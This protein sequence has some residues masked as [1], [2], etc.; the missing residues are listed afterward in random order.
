MRN[1]ITKL[2]NKNQFFLKI[3]MMSKNLFSLTL[4]NFKIF[5][6]FKVCISLYV[7]YS[8]DKITNCFQKILPYEKICC[9]YKKNICLLFKL[10]LMALK[11]KL[12]QICSVFIKSDW[13]IYMLLN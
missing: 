12:W 10:F 9:L 6:S 4:L 8:Y 3:Y 13:G 2:V 1:L 7:P 5:L 11:R